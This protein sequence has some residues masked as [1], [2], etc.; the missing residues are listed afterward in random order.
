MKTTDAKAW[1]Q[2]VGHSVEEARQMAKEQGFSFRVK[3]QDGEARIVTADL[4]TDRVNVAV[5]ANIVT[6]IESVG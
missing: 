1:S 5:E 4:R 2:L 6:A 3:T